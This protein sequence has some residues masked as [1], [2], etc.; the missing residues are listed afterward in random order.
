[1]PVRALHAGHTAGAN[2]EFLGTMRT[3]RKKDIEL[4]AT[5][6]AGDP[7][8]TDRELF[9]IKNNLDRFIFKCEIDTRPIPIDYIKIRRVI[10]ESIR[11]RRIFDD[12]YL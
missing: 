7:S 1:M 12:R 11:K 10:V 3:L 2:G 8:V 9:H 4:L 5:D 6:I